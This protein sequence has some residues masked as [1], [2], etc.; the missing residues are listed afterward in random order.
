M[1]IY[2]CPGMTILLVSNFLTP[3]PPTFFTII[4]P[5]LGKLGLRILFPFLEGT[6]VDNR[7]IL[8]QIGSVAMLFV[9]LRTLRWGKGEAGESSREV[10]LSHTGENRAH[11]EKEKK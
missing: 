8:D 6:S 5:V 10:V 11:G 3:L 9:P 1:K 7:L 2:P 4:S